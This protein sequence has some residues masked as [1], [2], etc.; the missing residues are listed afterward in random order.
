MYL[1]HGA[2]LPLCQFRESGF[3][4]L[5]GHDVG[6]ISPLQMASERLRAIA[7][8]LCDGTKCWCVLDVQSGERFP[9]LRLKRLLSCGLPISF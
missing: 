7:G 4:G 2:D 8:K 9:L 6:E 5:R 3:R 1:L